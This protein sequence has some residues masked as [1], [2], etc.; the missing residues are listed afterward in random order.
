MS[1]QVWAGVIVAAMTFLN[2]CGGG[3]FIDTKTGTPPVSSNGDYVYAVNSAAN[4]IEE[5]TLASGTLGLISG[6]PVT[7]L[8]GLQA[9]S[10]AVSR[11]N[12]FVWVGGNG[13]VSSY[14]IG[15][16]GALTVA[17]TQA[18]SATAN[19]V[20]MDTSPDGR[21]LLALDAKAFQIYVYSIN[22][23]TGALA[24]NQQYPYPQPIAGMGV[25]VSLR[26]SPNAAYVGAALGFGGEVLFAFNT[27]TGFLTALPGPQPVAN[28]ADNGIAF[29]GTNSFLYVTRVGPTSGTSSIQTFSI[30][31]TSGLTGVANVPTGNSPQGLLLDF[32]SAYL[33]SANAGAPNLFGFKIGA[34]TA[35]PSVG[36][37]TALPGSPFASGPSPSQLVE[38]K[39]HTYVVVSGSA[40]GTDLTLYKFDA[41]TPSS[42]DAVSTANSGTAGIVGLAATH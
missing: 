17:N 3:F 4:A 8:S 6:S 10:V 13:A 29:D 5:Y 9:S 19:F 31:A 7:A 16:S 2:G 41:F 32:T 22:T 27:S 38:D 12:N 34:T 20:S 25:P 37:L 39:T 30:N 26:I 24:V 40:G 35:S 42:L 18:A 33:Y 23:S 21:W 1:K 11:S 28:S 14:T 15:S 36:T